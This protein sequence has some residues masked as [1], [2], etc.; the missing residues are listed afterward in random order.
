MKI[1]CR[2]LGGGSTRSS[3]GLNLGLPAV[4]LLC[5]FFFLGGLFGSV[6][7][8]QDVVS[9]VRPKPR[10][11]EEVDK[12]GVDLYPLPHGDTGED[13]VTSIPFQILSWNP[14]ALYFPKFA[15]VEQCKSIIKLAEPQLRPSTLAYRKG[16]TAENTKGIRTSS[17]MFI[18]GYQD[19]TGI[20]DLIERKIARAT[21]LPRSHGE[22]FNILRYKTGQ[23]YD[24]H[25]D[26]FNPAEYGP[27][28]R[29]RV[30]SFL[31]Y[32]TDVEEGGETMFPLEDGLDLNKSYNYSDCIGLKVMPRRGDGLFF[33]SLFPNGT[34]DPRS[35]HGSCPVRKGEKWVAT[36]WIRDEEV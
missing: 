5:G 35:I 20:L 11:V 15:T 30:A 10:L 12:K 2:T 31:L 3:F 16:D 6:L 22:P 4:F 1:K 28:T 18:S 19:E 7:L 9:D 33:Y 34:I 17:G 27:Q 29:Q 13:S 25:Y 26:A 36:K 14:R 8:F 24:S 23:K 21:M 32:L